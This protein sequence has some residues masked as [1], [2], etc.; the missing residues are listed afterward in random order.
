MRAAQKTHHIQLE[1]NGKN[2]S[3]EEKNTLLQNPKNSTILKNWMEIKLE[4]SR[5]DCTNRCTGGQTD[6]ERERAKDQKQEEWSLV[7]SQ[8][9]AKNSRPNLILICF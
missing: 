8:T 3:A 5:E 1:N 4:L 6:R 7:T 9:T 2:I